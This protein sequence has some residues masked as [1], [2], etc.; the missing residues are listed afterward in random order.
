MVV[1]TLTME[2][3]THI[4]TS[5]DLKWC[6]VKL[7]PAGEECQQTMNT[8]SELTGTENLNLL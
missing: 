5:G 6:V 3:D 1:H 4:S 8:L 2:Q 7:S